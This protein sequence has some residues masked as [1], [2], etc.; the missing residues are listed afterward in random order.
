MS[1]RQYALWD[2]VRVCVYVCG[3]VCVC[4]SAGACL[5]VCVCVCGFVCVCCCA[6]AFLCVCVCV[7]SYVCV[8][9]SAVLAYV[10]VLES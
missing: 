2:E 5:C 1:E 9:H 10:C 6:G 7:C 8:Y 4:R 3:F